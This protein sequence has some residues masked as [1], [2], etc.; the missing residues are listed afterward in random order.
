[1][2]GRWDKTQYFNINFEALRTRPMKIREDRHRGFT[3]IEVL[4]ALALMAMIATILTTSL[5]IG[6][7]A[8]QR[9]TRAAAN[10]DEIAQAQ[11]FLR[12]HLSTIYPY[13]R[14]AAG[15]SMPGLLVS[16]GRSNEFSIVPPGF[17][18]DGLWR[19][20]IRISPE[21]HELEVR[22]RRDNPGV[23]GPDSEP[24]E[25]EALLTRIESFAVEFWLKPDN[26]PGRWADRWTDSASLPQLIRVDVTFASRDHRH[27]P[28]LYVEPRIDTPA[29]CEFDAV[30]RRCRSGA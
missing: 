18:S 10:A 6:G 21:T 14:T 24:W 7:H 9:V 12:R 4:V 25:S 15:V 17:A 20:Q 28:T 8:W 23:S 30:S 27:W 29:T 5:Q 2:G 11:E 26:S 16:D 19:Y 13:E 22:S 1:L 3:L